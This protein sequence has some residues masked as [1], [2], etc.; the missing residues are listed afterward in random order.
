MNIPRKQ[1]G[2]LLR[3]RRDS[4]NKKPSFYCD[5]REARTLII[6]TTETGEGTSSLMLDP[7]RIGISPSSSR[8]ALP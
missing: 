3:W 5:M 2:R 7:R 6:A 4:K 8:A 1:D